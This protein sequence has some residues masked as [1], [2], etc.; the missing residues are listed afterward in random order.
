MTNDT[1]GYLASL[2]GNMAHY[3][4]G[5]SSPDVRA[6]F[7]ERYMQCWHSALATYP[8]DTGGIPQGEAIAEMLAWLVQEAKCRAVQGERIGWA[9]MRRKS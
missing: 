2:L 3:H 6:Y 8:V 9:R 5:D 1:E 7:R 4:S